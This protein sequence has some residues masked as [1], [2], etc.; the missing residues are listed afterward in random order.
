MGAGLSKE[1]ISPI[2]VYIEDTDAGGIVYYV[3]Y[4]KY[5]E[6]ARTELFRELGIERPSMLTSGLL[7]VVASANIVYKSPAR[8]DDVLDVSA[9]VGKLARTYIDLKQNVYRSSLCLCQGEIRIACVER[10]TMKPK[11]LPEAVHQAFHHHSFGKEQG[12]HE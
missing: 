11:A 7:L 6:R 10:Q 9:Q 8:L 5:M 1:F 12:I 4:L 3:N 2:R